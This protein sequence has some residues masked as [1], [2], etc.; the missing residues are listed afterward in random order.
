[1]N[2]AREKPSPLLI[3]LFLPFSYAF[4]FLHH[5]IMLSLFLAQY[6]S[7]HIKVVQCFGN[8]EL[9]SVEMFRN[10]AFKV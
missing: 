1:M 2:S 5:D 6:N 3:P 4:F 10:F 8:C 9:L 7:Q